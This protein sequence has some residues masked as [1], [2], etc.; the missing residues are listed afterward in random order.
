M[1][2]YP[3]LFNRS[4]NSLLRM[5]FYCAAVV[6]V[7]P[8]A[9]GQYVPNRYALILE[10]PPVAER[11]ESRA[12]LQSLEAKSYQSQIQA[13]QR[14]IQGVLQQKNLQVTG[15]VTVVQNTVFVA[16]TPEEA[17]SLKGIDGVKA[18][19]PVQKQ[20]LKM[21][22]AVNLINAPAAW[23]ALGGIPNAGA[24]IKI[25]VVDTGVDHKNPAFLDPLLETPPG[26]PRCD[27][28][29]CAFTNNKVIAARSYV[30]YMVAGSGSDPAVNSR[31]D[32]LSPRDRGGH[33]TAVAASAAA[34]QTVAGITFSGVAPKAW[35]GNYKVYGSPDV[36]DGSSADAVIQALEDALLDGMDVINYSSGGPAVGDPL[37]TGS[38]CGYPAGVPCDLV[39]STF[40]RL[41]RQGVIL[42]VAAGNEGQDGRRYPTFNSIGSPANAPGVISVGA[43][44]NSHRFESMLTLSGAAVPPQLQKIAVI[45]SDSRKPSGGIEFQLRD[46]T[47]VGDDGYACSALPHR[48]L[49]GKFALVKNGSAGTLCDAG[50]KMENVVNAGAAGMILYLSESDSPGQISGLSRFAEPAVVI[51]NFHGTALKDFIATNGEYPVT[52]DGT[53][54]EINS[55]GNLSSGFSSKG[56]ATGK[57]ILKPEVVAPGANIF[58]STQSWDPLAGMFSSNGFLATD[59]TSFATPIT[60]GAAALVRQKNPSFTAEQV[61]SA[62]VNTATPD[63]AADEQGNLV[64]E[65]ST[66]AGKV[67][68]LAA[69]NPGVTVVPAVISYGILKTGTALPINQELRLTNVT[70]NPVTLE[71]AIKETSPSADASVRLNQQTL[72]LDAGATR[73]VTATLSGTSPAPGSYSGVVTATG[74]GISLRIP[75]LFMK[76]SGI[77]HN[78]IPLSGN[79]IEGETGKDQPQGAILLKV[80]D[81]YGIPVEGER[82]TWESTGGRY[83]FKQPE[84]DANGVVGAVIVLS[85]A[86]GM[87]RY[88]ARLSPGSFSVTG[89]ARLRPEVASQSVLNGASFDASQPIAPGSYISIFGKNLTD[90]SAGYTNSGRLPMALNSIRVS[91]DVPGKKLS[92]PGNMVYVSPEQVNVQVPWEL[93]GQQEV[94]VKVLSGGLNSNVVTVP[95]ANHSPAFFEIGTKNVAALDQDYRVITAEHPASA[96]QVIQ[97]FANG[98]GPVTNQ[99]DS[100]EVALGTT[101]SHTRAAPV[102]IIGEQP[103]EVIFS[104]LAPGFAGL[105]QVNVR[106]PAGLAAG[107]QPLKI[108]IGGKTSPESGIPVQ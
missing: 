103:A 88:T 57:A 93:Q 34:N 71:L 96:G 84:T 60:A 20:Y 67:D 105:Y 30:K 7:L 78:I 41:A 25:A 89:V 15:A 24:G 23:T 74:P 107:T 31:P 87:S 104:G 35:I 90:N 42:L 21:N 66:G 97:L 65:R 26:Y 73:I 91:F 69:L 53:G 6:S 79:F 17:E 11:F 108:T 95:L 49:A 50:E 8:G 46:V 39:A 55:V 99:P 13:Q 54:V 37:A 18:V 92:L 36:N 44:T 28:K 101:L 9:L 32:D 40:E 48:S 102:V 5:S 82:V 76:G 3:S 83:L 80:V 19:I 43:T 61:K 14:K 62:L 22:R 51:A 56:P 70:A 52:I 75:Y 38:D 81:M 68:V 33:G 10:D 63:I 27:G 94:K 4:L 85:G 86:P 1:K 29:D 98:L 100:G 59:G 72:V 64:D 2:I 45:P 12:S 106:I 16:A 77:A 58:M 47:V